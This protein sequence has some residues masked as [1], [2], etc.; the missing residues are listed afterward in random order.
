MHFLAAAFSA[1][2]LLA[3]FG[4]AG[5]ADSSVPEPFRGF[6]AAS[7]YTINYD[8]LDALLN[9]AV[10]NAGRLNGDKIAQAVARTGSRITKKFKS[11]T[12][13]D[14]N[15]FYFEAFAASEE[16]RRVLHNIRESLEQVPCE[17]A[18]QYFSR[19]E[20][21]AYWLNL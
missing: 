10:F 14:G 7:G 20:Q 13:Y 1:L 11:T 18:L 21:L 19:A 4:A 15:G 8:D 3:V 16:N 6:D 17:V 9:V 2:A 12:V 5:A